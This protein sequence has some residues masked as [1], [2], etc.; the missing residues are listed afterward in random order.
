MTWAKQAAV[1]VPQ[2][3]VKGPQV[4]LRQASIT[5]S[6]DDG[7]PTPFTALTADGSLLQFAP[8]DA[9]HIRTSTAVEGPGIDKMAYIVEVE[10][11]RSRYGLCASAKCQ[12]HRDGERAD[13]D[14]SP[15]N[16]HLFRD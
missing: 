10:E 16:F 5:P 13:I 15:R 12:D 3:P 7:D 6:D 14:R 8:H 1:P 11:E 4:T 2:T 9:K